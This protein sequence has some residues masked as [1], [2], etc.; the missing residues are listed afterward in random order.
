MVYTAKICYAIILLF[1]VA[2]QKA[3]HLDHEL[4]KNVKEGYVWLI[5]QN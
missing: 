1:F 3:I 5:K 4:W 2:L